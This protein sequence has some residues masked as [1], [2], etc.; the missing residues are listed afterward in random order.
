MF[1]NQRM[2]FEELKAR[3][4]LPELLQ[5]LGLFDYLPAVGTHRCPLHR[6]DRG[7]SFSIFQ[8]DHRWAWKCHGACGIGGDEL[9]LIETVLSCSRKN[10]AERYRFL[11]SN[12]SSMPGASPLKGTAGAR[13][14]ADCQPAIAFP[15]DLAPGSRQDLQ[16]VANLRKVDFWAVATM[17]KLGVLSFGT[18]LGQRCWIVLDQSRLCAEARRLDGSGFVQGRKAHTLR[19]SN[20][21]WPVGLELPSNLTESFR[22]F[23]L[24]EGSGDLVAAYHWCLRHGQDCLPI[25]LLGAG[26][27][28]IH[29][30]ALNQLARASVRIVPHDDPAGASAAEAW[31][32]Q[33]RRMGST[34]YIFRIH[35]I[36]LPDG[37][38]GKDLNDTTALGTAASEK[39]TGLFSWI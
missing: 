26:M 3:L 37:S 27:R 16:A 8:R 36:T 35:D 32:L 1:S 13:V 20:K 25:A 12:A 30:R 18:V 39:L 5:R 31:Q 14:R 34:V 33:L 28:H 21:S 29:P 2:S 19:G 4:P 6:E 23:L 38:R 10:A 24:V 11:A 22:R 17:Q 15:N 9:S 7:A